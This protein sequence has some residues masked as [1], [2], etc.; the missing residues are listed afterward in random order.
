V[1]RATGRRVDKSLVGHI[2]E[3]ALEVDLV[4]PRQ[5]ERPRDLALASR[6]VGR[7]DEV[8]DLLAGGQACGALG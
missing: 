8:E 6:L 7:G 1:E 5:P 4:L 3:Q 2:L